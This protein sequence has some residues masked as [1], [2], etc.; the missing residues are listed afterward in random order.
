[1]VAGEAGEGNTQANLL[2]I[3]W[4]S[5]WLILLSTLLG[6]GVGWA[7][8][9]RTTP[10]YT[11]S[12]Q[13]YVE[14]NLPKLLDADLSMM[15]S[16]NYLNTQAEIIRSTSVLSA[17][18]ELP[19]IRELKTIRETENPLGLLRKQVQV[20]VGSNNDIITISAELEDPQDAAAIVNA[21]VD[22]YVTEYAEDQRT[23]LV[24]LLDILREEKIRRDGE[25]EAAQK[26]LDDFRRQHIA[27]AVQVNN[28]NVINQRFGML[29]GELNT[30]EIELLQAKAQYNRIKKMYDTPSQRPFLLEM[31]TANSTHLRDANLEQQVRQAEQA[32]RA[33]LARWGE[34]YPRVK[35]LQE[36]LDELKTRLAAQRT[37]IVE[38]YVEG[39]RQQADLLQHKRDE[40]QTAYDEQFELA[41]DVSSQTVTLESLKTKLVRAEQNRDLI[42]ERIKQLSLSKEKVAAMNVDIMETA[43]AGWQ[44]YPERSK[45]LGM[46]VAFGGM[47][48]FGLA[49]LR[50]LLDHRLKSIEEIAEV[51]QLPIMGAIPLLSGDKGRHNSGRIVA[52][53]P[54]SASAEA[55]RTLRTGIHFGLGGDEV[56]VIAVTSPSPGDGKSTVASNLAIAISQVEG[57]V[58]LIDADMRKP[59]QGEIFGIDTPVGLSSVL[60]E[61]RPLAE[62]ILHTDVESL[63]IL[64]CGKM[65][66]NPV[67]L[68]NKG[69]FT[70]MLE[71]LGKIYD[72]VIIDSPP[73]MPVA[74]ARVICAASDCTLLVLRAEKATKRLSTGARDELWR[75]RA[76]RLGVAVNAVPTRKQGYGYGYGAYGGQYGSYGEVAYGY[77]D[78]E[79][80]RR[81]RKTS[82]LS[83]PV[84]SNG[85]QHSR[86]AA[87]HAVTTTADD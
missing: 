47:F 40:L 16:A 79:L 69:G 36:S 52:D 21:I 24:G 32:L 44:S 45:F 64:P 37:Q 59:V 58:L 23:D 9:Q 27:L 87:P 77:D 48:G 30:T 22:A 56:K 84:T 38:G 1:M 75:V 55:F 49:W 85:K 61:Q 17:A 39:L 43:Q 72:K 31:A 28:D 18:L 83:K 10:R 3:A 41:T 13:I 35:L 8:L 2:A 86:S 54:R 11:S 81:N 50:D 57:R 62:A 46:G 26:S 14:R 63:D 4:R 53:Q 80:D 51:M 74:D 5:R 20:G 66:S 70:Q 15:Q 67:E 76:Q 33:E 25:L 6:A 78:Q 73:V 65:P 29:A 7:I 60:A 19:E 82:R 34:G 42:D 71:E 12:S 68:L